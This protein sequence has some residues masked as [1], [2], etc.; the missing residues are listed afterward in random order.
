MGGRRDRD[1]TGGPLNGRF[2][3]M[4]RTAKEEGGGEDAVPHEHA[5]RPALQI[6]AEPASVAGGIAVL[7]EI[8]NCDGRLIRYAT[9]SVRPRV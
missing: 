9:R 6:V 4:D 1:A 2:L 3:R 8:C 7:P 5:G